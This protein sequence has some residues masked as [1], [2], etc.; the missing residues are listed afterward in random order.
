MAESLSGRCCRQA[1]DWLSDKGRR[2]RPRTGRF[3]LLG[4]ASIDSGEGEKVALAAAT[5][6]AVIEEHR[7]RS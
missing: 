5:G 7:V 2:R 4:S 3:L 6:A 1:S